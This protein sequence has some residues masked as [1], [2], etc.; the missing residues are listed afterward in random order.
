MSSLRA[1][2]V[3]PAAIELRRSTIPSA[4]FRGSGFRSVATQTPFEE[5]ANTC[6]AALGLAGAFGFALALFWHADATV[7]QWVFAVAL[8][9]L[10]LT[11]TAYHGLSGEPANG[12]A[13]FLL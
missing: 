1:R 7:G 4:E 3:V 5:L 9:I 10:F 12:V 6:S 8:L 2:P 13:R 11:S